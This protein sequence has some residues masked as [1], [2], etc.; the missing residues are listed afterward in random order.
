MFFNDLSQI[1]TL[2]RKTGFSIFVVDQS[3][4]APDT[5]SPK[6]TRKTAK[7]ADASSPA[8]FFPELQTFIVPTK[9]DTQKVGIA[10]VRLVIDHCKSHQTADHFVVF[11]NALALTADSQDAMLKLLE[12]PHE[13]YHF[14]IFT[15]DLSPLLDTILS[16]A[17]IFIQSHPNILQS[18]PVV[19][20]TTLDFAK[21][22]LS[23]KPRDLLPLA[24]EIASPKT[25]KD[26]RKT[27][28]TITTTAIELAYKYY[29]ST[30]NPAFIKKLPNLLKLDQSLKGNGNVKLHLVADLL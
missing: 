17:N 22:L 26:P 24:D 21:R 28:L 27:A 4:I 25:S 2:T 13:N 19:D 9:S 16:R 1:P 29:F 12:E 20:Q 7:A 8:R 15:S 11:E 10:E 30:K 18:P 6:T 14:V 5:S 3:A 23:A